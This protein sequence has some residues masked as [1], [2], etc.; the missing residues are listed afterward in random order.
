MKAKQI[1]LNTL[2]TQNSLI[3][4]RF[5]ITSNSI[6]YLPSSEE[7]LDDKKSKN[8]CGSA[9][10][11]VVEQAAKKGERRPSGIKQVTSN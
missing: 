3:F 6:V 1:V 5:Q 10:D 9:E 8:E 7:K 11:A 4:I 2:A